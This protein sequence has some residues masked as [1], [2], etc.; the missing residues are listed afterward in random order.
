VITNIL[1][2]VFVV[3]MSGL[4][5]I[6]NIIPGGTFDAFADADNQVQAVTNKQYVHIRTQQRNGRK[7]LTTV[8]GLDKK[9]EY[10]KVL[11]AFK[12]KFNCNGTIVDDPEYGNV[13]QLQGDQRQNVSQFLTEEGICKKD[14]IKIHGR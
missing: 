11:K 1:S 13:I 2:S 7:S 5:D 4:E 12:K 14:I 8:Q 6:D 10:S 3:Y 9:F